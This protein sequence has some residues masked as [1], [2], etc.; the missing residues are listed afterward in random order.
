MGAGIL[1]ISPSVLSVIWLGLFVLL[2]VIEL[3]TVGLTTI[4]FAIGSL[5][6][7]AANV[8]GG[9]L[10]VQIIAFLAVSVVM[11]IFTRPWAERN[12][13][14]KRVKTNY[15]SR[16]GQ[17][18]RITEKVDN[19]SQTGKSIIDGVEWTVRAKD[20]GETFEP[21]TLA[22]VSDVSGVKLIVEKCK[23]ETT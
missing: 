15:E 16:I 3:L 18:I 5:A 2:L 1:S 6:G 10:A 13:N 23:E 19:L 14:R 17:T 4:W 7:L 11:L 22:R 9:N 12:L 21:G 20:D 8:L